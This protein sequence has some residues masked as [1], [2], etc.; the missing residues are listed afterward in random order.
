[1]EEMSL[2]LNITPLHENGG[3]FLGKKIQKATSEEQC[4][5]ADYRQL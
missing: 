5:P 3:F 2:K 1:M 4:V